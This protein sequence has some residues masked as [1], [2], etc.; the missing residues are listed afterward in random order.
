M[1]NFHIYMLL[2]FG[3]VLFGFLIKIV[4]DYIGNNLIISVI[5]LVVVSWLFF[6]FFHREKKEKK[7]DKY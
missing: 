6:I 4:N 1:M 5:I 3:V 2:V 7:S